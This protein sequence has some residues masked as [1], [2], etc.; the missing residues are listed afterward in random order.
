MVTRK[1]TKNVK[2]VKCVETDQVLGSSNEA[3]VTILNNPKLASSIAQT[4][5]GA[6]K[7]AGGYHWEYVD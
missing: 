5:K 2:R 3:A 7:S 6:R 4:C 1:I